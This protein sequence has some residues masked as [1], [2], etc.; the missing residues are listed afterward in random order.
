MDH[1]KDK[2]RYIDKEYDLSQLSEVY[3]YQSPF[4][5]GEWVAHIMLEF[6]FHPKKGSRKKAQSLFL[7]VEARRDPGEGYSFLK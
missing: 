4:G 2:E 3:M 7:S 5:Y 6:V 1:E